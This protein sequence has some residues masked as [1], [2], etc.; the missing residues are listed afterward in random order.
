[1][2]IFP[3]ENIFVYPQHHQIIFIHAQV[4]TCAAKMVSRYDGTAQ[5][6]CKFL[7]SGPLERNYLVKTHIKDIYM[8]ILGH[9]SILCLCS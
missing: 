3:D 5:K 6:C 2:Q 8:H 7:Q 1:M 4:C 9:I